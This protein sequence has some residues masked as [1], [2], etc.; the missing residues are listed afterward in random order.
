MFNLH[1][2]KLEHKGKSFTSNSLTI[3]CSSFPIG[4]VHLIYIY[5]FL[6]LCCT[7]ILNYK[8]TFNSIHGFCLI[9]YI[10]CSY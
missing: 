2:N 1:Q 8:R 10:F 3:E 6:L 4:V 9:K 5:P 7:P